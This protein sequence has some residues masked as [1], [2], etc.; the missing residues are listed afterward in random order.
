MTNLKAPD[1]L[2]KP[3]QSE[4]QVAMI[5]FIGFDSRPMDTVRI[6]KDPDTMKWAFENGDN[7]LRIFPSSFEMRLT[8]E[9]YG[10]VPQA[11]PL[12]SKTP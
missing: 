8:P 11:Q 4:L 10:I 7:V 1:I 2:I 12:E 6:A 5:T 3:Y 9:D